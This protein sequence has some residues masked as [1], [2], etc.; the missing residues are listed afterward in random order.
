MNQEITY[1]FTIYYEDGNTHNTHQECF[2]DAKVTLRNLKED[3]YE[4]SIT[5]WVGNTGDEISEYFFNT[6]NYDSNGFGIE[7]VA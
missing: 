6:E 4:F 3:N 2:E 7:E 1:S 5:K